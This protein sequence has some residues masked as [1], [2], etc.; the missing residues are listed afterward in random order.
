[1]GFL[2]NFRTNIL[3]FF[4][5]PSI[6]VGGKIWKMSTTEFNLPLKYDYNTIEK[7][8]EDERVYSIVAM[9][10]SMVQKA[11]VGPEIHPKNRF[12]DDKLDDK[13]EKAILSAIKFS[14]DLNF[15]QLCFDYAWQLITHGDLFEKI[16]KGEKGIESITSLPLGSTRVLANE[17]Q[18]RQI[19]QGAQITEEKMITVKKTTNDTQPTLHK[20]GEYFHLSFKNHGVWR[21][22]IDGSDTYSI[23]SIPPI[24]TLQRLI[25]WKKKTIENDIIWKNKLLPRILYKL[26]MPSIIPSKYT[27]TQTEKVAAAQADA[28]LLTT[29]FINSTKTLRPD[30]DIVMSDA[31]DAT[32][33][34]ASSVNYQK[35][36][37]TISQI[38]T[39]LNT[40]QGIPSGLLGGET[41]ASVAIELAAIFAGIRVDYLVSKIA[42]ALTRVMQSHLRIVTPSAGN[43]VIERIFIHTDPALS[44][45]KFE[46]VK[47]ALS[48]T[49][50]G[51]FTKGEIRQAAGYP[52][53]P[54]LP[55]ET[56]PEIDLSGLRSSLGDRA[57]D[58][59]KEKPGSDKNNASPQAERNTMEEKK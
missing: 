22:D 5:D 10:S 40:P 26:K 11:Y 36:N 27:G 42:V 19:G 38:N 17:S 54:Q 52:R 39:F 32:M 43:D 41:G 8:T 53:L 44:V 58:I 55:K 51:V 18:Q 21:K 9:V 56:F 7:L 13:E 33:L 1:M 48:M 6:P 46:K 24:A 3:Q 47:T 16:V 20:E 2:S 37:E 28:T 4:T 30:D 50:I 25:N 49:A 14:R 12:T 29:K 15:K 23:Y 35:P 57:G 34:E 59:K 31:A 45:E